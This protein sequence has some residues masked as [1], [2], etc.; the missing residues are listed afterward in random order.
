MP[1]E[2]RAPRQ[3]VNL[4]DRD[5]PR[6]DAELLALD[7][8][9]YVDYGTVDDDYVAA[10]EAISGRTGVPGV[11]LDGRL[12]QIPSTYRKLGTALG[13][14]E[15][16]SRLAAEAERVLA[17][18]RATLA[19]TPLRVYLACSQNGL[20]P[21]FRGHSAGEAL[22]LLGAIN[23]AGSIEDAARRPL[24]LAEVRAF[25]PDVIVADEPRRSRDDTRQRRLAR[26]RGR[27]FRQGPR[28]AHGPVQLGAETAVR[29]PARRSALA[30]VCAARSTV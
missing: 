27:R 12:T 6:Y 2:Y 18:Y 13:V 8:D 1:P 11:I 16:G 3:I 22:E 10:L 25:A 26:H 28:T 24:T 14:A 19:G 29:Q 23:V 30:R 21:C 5:D 20:S 17:K 9:V 7:V 4:P 15:R